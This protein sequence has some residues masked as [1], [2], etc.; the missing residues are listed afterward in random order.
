[1]NRTFV[2][3]GAWAAFVAVA[4]G[5]FGT[6]ALRGKL[7]LVDLEVWRTAVQYHLIHALALIAVGL[8]AAQ[9]ENR[10]LR[11]SGWLFLAGILLFGGSLYAL[12]LTDRRILGAITPLGGLCFLGGW[13]TFALGVSR[14]T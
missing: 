5:A 10:L 6:H 7:S 14:R 3:I 13:A 2:A 1:M 9:G 11:A 4:L 8:A 12:A